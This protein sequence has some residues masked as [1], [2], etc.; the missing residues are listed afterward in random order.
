M[1]CIDQKYF[2]FVSNKYDEERNILFNYC[3]PCKRSSSIFA[4]ESKTNK[5]IFCMSNEWHMFT[6]YEH[7]IFVF[8]YLNMTLTYYKI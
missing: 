1:N 6:V 3:K 5:L 8:E 7:E 2:L 4:N